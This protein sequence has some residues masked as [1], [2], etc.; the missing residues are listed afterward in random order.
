ME[1][2][3]FLHYNIKPSIN[4]Y[5]LGNSNLDRENPISIKTFDLDWVPSC[6][7]YS[8]YINHLDFL[9]DQSFY[10]AF[11]STDLTTSNYNF[12]TFF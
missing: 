8:I 2:L 3:S 12:I 4:M 9:V 11:D 10:Q 6:Q 7:K 1:V 5:S